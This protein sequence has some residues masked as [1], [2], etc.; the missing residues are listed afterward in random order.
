[1]PPPRPSR[2]HRSNANTTN[3]HAFFFAKTPK[4]SVLHTIIDTVLDLP[5]TL[6]YAASFSPLETI[7]YYR[8]PK[9]GSSAL[10]QHLVNAARP[11]PCDRGCSEGVHVFDRDCASRTRVRVV[12]H[13]HVGGCQGDVCNGSAS[14]PSFAVLRE[15]CERFASVLDQVSLLPMAPS[16]MGQSFAVGRHN[17]TAGFVKF[18]AGLLD[19]CAGDDIGC[20]VR[21]FNAK[22]KGDTRIFLYPQAY[23]ISAIQPAESIVCYDH[24]RLGERLDAFFNERTKCKAASK[25]VFG[26]EMVKRNS[27]H[28]DTLAVKQQQ[29]WCQRVRQIY[30][31]DAQLWDAHCVGRQNEKYRLTDKNSSVGTF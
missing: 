27:R 16:E 13:D 22:I 25:P 17:D 20:A 7:H 29:H 30:A 11:M 9:T 31:R 6:I 18:V 2:K 28:H 8:T 21:H 23:F 1:M 3:P 19:G 24:D 12:V 14:S 15:P 10:L 5:R 4:S 26:K